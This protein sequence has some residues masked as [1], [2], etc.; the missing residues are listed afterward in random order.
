MSDDDFEID[1]EESIQDTEMRKEA[2]VRSVPTIQYYEKT[3]G[4]S[5]EGNDQKAVKLFRTYESQE[6]VRRLQNELIMVKDRQVSEKILDNLIGKKRASRYQGYN[7]WAERLLIWLA[8]KRN[9]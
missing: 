3:Y 1:P 7:V 4:R 5:C 6:K 2:P 8:E 9:A